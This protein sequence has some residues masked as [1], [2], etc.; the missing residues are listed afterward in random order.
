MKQL[1]G[2]R[3]GWMWCVNGLLIGCLL[4]MPTGTAEAGPGALIAKVF[5]AI[6]T[7]AH[8]LMGKGWAAGS[9]AAGA[10][11]KT[12]PQA[13]KAAAKTV[14]KSG[15]QAA[16][17]VSRVGTTTG[18]KVAG[19]TGAATAT[20]TG[21]AGSQ[22]AK[23]ASGSTAAKA[24]DKYDKVADTLTHTFA[25]LPADLGVTS[26]VASA[27]TKVVSQAVSRTT[28]SAA[29]KTVEQAG[30]KAAAQVATASAK[31]ASGA[32]SRVLKHLGPSGGAILGKLNPNSTARLAEMS[33]LLARSPHKAQWMKLLGK[34]GGSCVDFLWK[35]KK[36]ILV[37][38]TATAVVLKPGDFLASIGSVAE[39]SVT[40]AGKV[41]VN[42]T[43]KAAEHVAKPLAMSVASSSSWHTF[44]N[45]VFITLFVVVA[46]RCYAKRR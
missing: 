18:G 11:G 23:A 22:A 42:M 2:K 6:G 46:A 37:G 38:T 1:Y 13:G 20:A 26:T 9:R 45:F 21:G 30:R 35:H 4:V 16:K 33:S 41:A 43:D 40:T 32:A 12:A 19:R 5:Q 3:T 36:G 29:A 8:K 34:H 14:G 31:A 28:K 15:G 24:G 10:A 17:T 44:W 25:D 39:A 27:G 7:K